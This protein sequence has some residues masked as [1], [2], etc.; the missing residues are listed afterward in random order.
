MKI[1]G[2]ANDEELA[3]VRN[4]KT[5][6]ISEQQLLL[7]IIY[8]FVSPIYAFSLAGNVFVYT[9]SQ[10]KN[11]EKYFSHNNYKEN[12]QCWRGINIFPAISSPI[13]RIFCIFRS[14]MKGSN[15]S[16]MDMKVLI[17]AP[18]QYKIVQKIIHNRKRSV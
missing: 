18:T 15:P 16:E 5:K 7:T 2:T 12:C 6:H 11:R 1:L 9:P 4:L 17:L 10:S 13:E 8:F 14:N 3:S